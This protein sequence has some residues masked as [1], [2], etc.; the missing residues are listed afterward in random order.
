MNAEIISVGTELLL[1]QVLNTDAQFLS[2]ELATLGIDVY[3]HTVVG[4][5]KKRLLQALRTAQ[6]R[7]DIIIMTGGLGPTK[8]DLTKE[9]VAEY[10]NLELVLHEKSMENIKS[11]F[12]KMNRHFTGSRYKQAMFPKGALIFPNDY[13]TAPGCMLRETGH[14]YIMLPGPPSEL[15]PMFFKYIRNH[16]TSI[17]STKI[18]TRLI[19]TYGIGEL[20]VEDKLRDLFINQKNPTIASLVEQ[21]GVTLRITAKASSEDEAKEMIYPMIETIKDRLADAVFG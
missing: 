14:T 18:Y 4:D 15:R 21:A 12:V 9:T 3:F 11:Y 5:N 2:Q 16:L 10:L 13:G 17:S 8:D 7:A 20:S 6:K 19:K 1:G